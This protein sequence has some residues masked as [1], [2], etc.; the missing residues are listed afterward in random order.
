VATN[1]FT[2][3]PLPESGKQQHKL[4][5]KIFTTTPEKV[6]RAAVK[7]IRRNRRLVVIEPSARFL[8]TVKRLAPS[9]VDYFLHLGR[10]NRIAKKM[11]RLEAEQAA[12][13][14]KAA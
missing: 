11:A 10:R 5:P 6:A 2:S 8:T 12:P 14:S 7:A 3:A 9:V 1:L 13:R 4:P